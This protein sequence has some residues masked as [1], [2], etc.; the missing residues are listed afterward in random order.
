MIQ[1]CFDFF[2]DMDISMIQ[3]LKLKQMVEAGFVQYRNIFRE[4][5]KQKVQTEMMVYFCK[6]T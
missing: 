3:A 5:K 2:Y 6:A 4:V 1:D